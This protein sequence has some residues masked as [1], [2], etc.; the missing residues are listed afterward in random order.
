MV[1]NYSGID[2]PWLIEVVRNKRSI[3]VSVWIGDC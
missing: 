2:A 1:K 3:A